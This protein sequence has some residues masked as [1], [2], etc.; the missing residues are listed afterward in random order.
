MAKE[1]VDVMIKGGQA[2]PAP[3]IG[4]ALSPLG[5]NVMEV[6]KEIN[7]KTKFFAGME[8]PVKIIIDTDTKKFTTSVG[9]PPVTSMI[10]K[11]MKKEKLATVGE[12]KVRKM[13]GSISLEAVI[14]IAKS[15]D[16]WLLKY[17]ALVY[18]AINTV[19]IWNKE[20]MKNENF[21]NKCADITLAE[22]QMIGIKM[23]AL[24]PKNEQKK[25]LDNC[26]KYY[27]PSIEPDFAFLALR[28]WAD[29]VCT[30]LA[31]KNGLVPTQKE[32]F[33]RIHLPDVIKELG[34]IATIAFLRE[35]PSYRNFNGYIQKFSYF[36][37]DVQ[38][39]K[40]YIAFDSVFFPY[41]GKRR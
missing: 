22:L 40:N 18:S 17:G 29:F 12:D 24:L 28:V 36:L 19:T 23:C 8:V 7:E 38:G 21:R 11:E 39:L 25:F 2:T 6:V 4:P 26:A 34:F 37:L 33:P 15:K 10:K 14:T 30:P 3:P 31:E 35:L 9:T 13:A 5:V 16:S 27:P 41:I 32:S 1:K 20:L